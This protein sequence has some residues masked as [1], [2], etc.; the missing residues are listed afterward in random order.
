[1]DPI[2]QTIKL[3]LTQ[4]GLKVIGAV[5]ILLIGRYIA[6]ILSKIV[7]GILSKANVDKTLISFV[8]NLT[9]FG[10]L[11]FVIIAALT[12]LGVQT[13]TLV[14]IVGAAGL[15]IGLALQGSLA[16]FAAGLILIIFKPFHVGDLIEAGGMLG[17]VEEIQIF[18]TILNTLDNRRVFMPNSKITSDNIINYSRIEKRRVDLVFSVS[19]HDD[20]KKAKESLEKV[21]NAD[22]RVLKD[23]EPTIAV[24]KLGESGVD[25]VCRPWVKPDDYWGVYFDTLEKGKLALEAG[26]A[27]IPFFQSDVHIY[28]EK[29]GSIL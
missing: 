28:Q 4:Y 14:A 27:T 19:Y 5:L 1:M 12:Q 17:I 6:S 13:A 11:I 8:Q 3:Y 29:T 21:L 18:V 20:I 9:Y 23:P 16:N 25:L 15:A 7:K 2:I 22:S 10:L 26:G 24:V